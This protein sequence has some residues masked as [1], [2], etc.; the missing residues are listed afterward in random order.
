MSSDSVDDVLCCSC[1]SERATVYCPSCAVS[2]PT[3]T[4]L[5]CALCASCDAESHSTRLASRHSR[6]PFSSH[7]SVVSAL[8]EAR[9][10]LSA[11]AEAAREAREAESGLGV[12]AESA[13]GQAREAAR[14]IHAAVDARA[15]AIADQVSKA[16]DDANA[17]SGPAGG[18][19][20]GGCGGIEARLKALCK[21]AA[22]VAASSGQQKSCLRVECMGTQEVDAV[23]AA[24]TALG[25]VSLSSS[26]KFSKPCYCALDADG[27]LFVSDHE[28]QVIRKLMPDV[29]GVA[30]EVGFSDGES[31]SAMFSYPMGL[32][33]NPKTEELLIADS[34]NNRI[35]VLARD[36]TVRTLAGSGQRS[37]IDGSLLDSSFAQPWAL[38]ICPITGDLFVS[39]VTSHMIR[40]VRCTGDGGAV[41]TVAGCGAE[42]FL[43]GM[44][45]EAKFSD[46]CGLAVCPL[47]GTLVIGD[48][49]NCRLRTLSAAGEVRTL[50]GCSADKPKDGLGASAGFSGPMGLCTDQAGNVFVADFLCGAIRKVSPRG[51]VGTVPQPYV[52]SGPF[53]VA[54]DSSGR[55]LFVVEHNSNRVLRVFLSN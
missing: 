11:A 49:G 46:V 23:I 54:M 3:G 26:T 53:G 41:V 40:R 51:L 27:G 29:A 48:T 42:G 33:Y 7:S 35:R 1:A 37:S 36:G 34:G 8:A 21:V 45:L 50:V 30:G 38:C 31:G 13:R 43:D 10:V 28:N 32:A 39:D 5:G 47:T 24:I 17:A 12:Q 2:S 14:R 55:S 25:T 52:L 18:A 19:P 20:G 22:A 9:R 4:T 44:A 15:A 16:I 6:C